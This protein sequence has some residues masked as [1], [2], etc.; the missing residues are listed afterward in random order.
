M[1]LHYKVQEEIFADRRTKTDVRVRRMSGK[2]NLRA[3]PANINNYVTCYFPE[4]RS[5]ET[6]KANVM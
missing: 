4:N 3:S 5:S 1:K 6:L 2:A